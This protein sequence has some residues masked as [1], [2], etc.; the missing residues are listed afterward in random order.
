[1][2]RA[3]VIDDEKRTRNFITM[4]ISSFGLDIE[5]VGQAESVVTALESITKINLI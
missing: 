5:V 2:K 4:L 3:L 1:M